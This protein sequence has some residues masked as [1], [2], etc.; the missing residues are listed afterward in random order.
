MGVVLKGITTPTSGEIKINGAKLAY[1]W[2]I[3]GVAVKLTIIG[4]SKQC[5]NQSLEVK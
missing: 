2:Y 4:T 3:L 5:E 1:Q